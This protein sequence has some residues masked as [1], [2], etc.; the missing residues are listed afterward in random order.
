MA[1]GRPFPKG[2]SGNEGGRPK[3][4][5]YIKEARERKYK[6]F[7]KAMDT[8]GESSVEEIDKILKNKK[9]GAFR[10]IYAKVI[11]EC[12][13]GNMQAM[14]LM[15][16]YLLGKPKELDPD[17]LDVSAV[18]M[19]PLQNATPEQ[20]KNILEGNVLTLPSGEVG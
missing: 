14:R 11:Q 19:R 18:N 16:E 13:R 4:D 2:V 10:A 6:E 15:F 9:S 7:V 1:V 20:L 5:P 3:Q 17:A 8:L 12:Y